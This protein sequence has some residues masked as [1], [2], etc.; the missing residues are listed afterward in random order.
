[1]KY[2]IMYHGDSYASYDT[3]EELLA[4][5]WMFRKLYGMGACYIYK[6]DDLSEEEE[7]IIDA[8][9]WEITEWGYR[10]DPRGSKPKVI[11]K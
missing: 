11:E 3:L 10:P 1:M 8:R 4:D 2:S 9:S 5:E 7:K 6:S